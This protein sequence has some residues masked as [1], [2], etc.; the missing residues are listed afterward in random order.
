M[1]SGGHASAL[2]L[3]LPLFEP[4]VFP[5]QGI[6]GIRFAGGEK[7]YIKTQVKA[8]LPDVDTL[9]KDALTLDLVRVLHP[10]TLTHQQQ[11]QQQQQQQ[12]RPLTHREPTLP[13]LAM[14]EWRP[15]YN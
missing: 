8:R 15:C 12:R 11:Q 5:L 7:C 2:F 1:A 13:L 9:N 3:W 14:V 6:T 4:A 10:R